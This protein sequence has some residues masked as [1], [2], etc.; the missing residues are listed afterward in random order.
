MENRR[1]EDYGVPHED[2]RPQQ[3]ETVQWLLDG[4]KK[5]ARVI[6]APTGSG[7]TTLARAVGSQRSVTALCKTKMLQ[8]ENYER[9][10]GF[11][12]LFGRG[13]YPCAL[14]PRLTGAECEFAEVG[15]HECPVVG[16]CPYLMQKSVAMGSDLRSLNYAYWLTARWP[17]ECPT[18]V[19]V[20]DEA[21]LLSETVLDFTGATI[22]EK[23]RQDWGLPPFPK[24]TSHSGSVLF[25]SDPTGDALAWLNEARTTLLSIYNSLNKAKNDLK[26]LRKCETLGMKI[27]ATIDALQANSHDWYIASG[28]AARSVGESAAP[29]FVCRPLTARHHAPQFFTGKWQT[30][31]M[32]ATI[33]DTDAFAREL[34]I[35]QYDARCVPGAWPP[36][37]RP[38]LVPKDA[39]K[40][41]RAAMKKGED[42]LEQQVRLIAQLIKGVPKEWSGV[43]HHTSIS[44]TENL[45]RRMGRFGL[46]DRVWVPPA[47]VGTEEQMAAW[48][49]HKKKVPNALA[50]TWGWQTGVDLLDEK[51]CIVAKTP[52]PSLANRY[53]QARLAYDGKFYLQRTAWALEQAC[54]RTR[55][56][57]SE[58]YDTPDEMRGLVAI[59]DNNYIRVQ[60][61]LSPAF[62]EALLVV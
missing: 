46:G 48:A 22:F 60:K 16:E 15:M 34:G 25:K 1:P 17:R 26:R 39:P 36:E 4:D 14:E 29:G 38:I 58:D 62:R 5:K 40:M 12:A 24:I 8:Q 47:Q 30:V 10:Y 37:S 61:Y 31:F 6:E 50:L 28:P 57:R 54:G 2:W 18:D 42:A 56:G 32:S 44:E 11:D 35:E 33:G 20:C 9:A 52:F 7:K 55:R 41:G 23:Q 19:V 51:I 53:E 13:N 3:Y 45:A 43:V 27:R 21:H 49:A 59:V